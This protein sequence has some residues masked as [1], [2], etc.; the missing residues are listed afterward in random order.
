MAAD[1]ILKEMDLTSWAADDL[2]VRLRAMRD[3][4]MSA[5]NHEARAA[6]AALFDLLSDVDD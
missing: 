4:S 1:I 2:A 3:V 6:A 5:E